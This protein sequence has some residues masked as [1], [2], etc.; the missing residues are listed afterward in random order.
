MEEAEEAE[1]EGERTGG[2]EGR[3]ERMFHTNEKAKPFF[4]V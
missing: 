4:F 3:K 1:E 2:L